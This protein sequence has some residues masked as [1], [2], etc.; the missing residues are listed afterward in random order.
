MP[1]ILYEK[2]DGIGVITL[3]RPEKLNPMGS[4]HVLPKQFVPYVLRNGV[5]EEK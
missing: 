2:T 5:F 1:I 4:R 3:N